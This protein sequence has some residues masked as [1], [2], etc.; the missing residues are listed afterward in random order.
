MGGHFWSYSVPY[1]ED[2]RAALEALR[3]QEFRTGRFWQPTEVQPGFFGRLLGRG[4]SKPKRPASI[5]E[6]LKTSDATGTRS[7]LDMERVSDTPDLGAVSPLRPEELHLY[8]DGAHRFQIRALRATRIA[9]LSRSLKT[10]ATMSSRKR[11]PIMKRSTPN[12]ATILAF[13]TAIP[14]LLQPALGQNTSGAAKA[15]PLIQMEGVPLSDAIRNL[16]T[17]MEINYLLDA[18]ICRGGYLATNPPINARWHLTAEQALQKVLSEHG[19]IIVSNAATSV[20]RILGTDAPIKQPLVNQALSDTNSVI[21]ELKIDSTL[22]KAIEDIAGKAHLA[23]RVD[24]KL[25]VPDVLGETKA[26][27]CELWFRWRNIKPRQ[28]LAALLDNYDLVI[29]EGPAK[30]SAKLITRAQFEAERSRNAGKGQRP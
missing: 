1:Q 8:A 10:A 6:A 23:M 27:D 3:E 15:P 12:K 21:P 29:A 16:A 19:L 9:Q 14:V 17:Q 5:R 11:K 4:P 7:I 22:D 18:R 28:A 24:P 20:A 2:I 26:E 25:R 13:L 30:N